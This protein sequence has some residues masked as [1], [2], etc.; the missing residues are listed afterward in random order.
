MI[1]HIPFEASTKWSTVRRYCHIH[2]D[3]YILNGNSLKSFQSVQL[4]NSH[5]RFWY[6]FG[7]LRQPAIIWSMLT[8]TLSTM[9]STHHPSCSISVHI[10]LSSTVYTL[11]LSH[12][13][14]SLCIYS[15]CI[16]PH[17]SC[18]M[19]IKCIISQLISKYKLNVFQYRY[20]DK[21]H[22]ILLTTLTHD[23]K[24]MVTQPPRNDCRHQLWVFLDFRSF[25]VTFQRLLI[26]KKIY[27]R[28]AK[29]LSSFSNCP[30]S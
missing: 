26:L 23:G 15:Y 6:W 7:T 14:F 9:W 18:Y 1:T 22:G 16:I 19:T 2:F 12:S 17:D 27:S 5:H 28:F 10:T 8:N 20:I 24:Y 29:S 30:H 13:N 21:L 25:I 11:A 4:T 3:K